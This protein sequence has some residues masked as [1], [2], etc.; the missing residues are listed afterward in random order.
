[1]TSSP[2]G[3]MIICELLVASCQLRVGFCACELVFASRE[4]VFASCELS[5]ASW[6]LRVESSLTIHSFHSFVPTLDSCQGV[7]K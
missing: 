6:F 2:W 4:L 1:M 3:D 7:F 5:V